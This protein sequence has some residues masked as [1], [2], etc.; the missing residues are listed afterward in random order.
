MLRSLLQYCQYRGTSYFKLM[1]ILNVLTNITH[2]QLVGLQVI[3]W[4][5]EIVMTTDEYQVWASVIAGFI[6][7]LMNL[8][9]LYVCINSDFITN[10]NNLNT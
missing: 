9:L 1:A 3:K 7:F 10:K 5:W 4:G 8:K 6:I 2:R